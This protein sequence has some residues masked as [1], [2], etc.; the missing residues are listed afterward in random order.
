ML[1]QELGELELGN[2]FARSLRVERM[3]RRITAVAADGRLDPPRARARAAADEHEVLAHEP[4][5]TQE[6]LEPTMG[7]VRPGHDEQARGVTVQPVDDS[8]P[9]RLSASLDRL[10]EQALDE[11]AVGMAGRRMDDDPRRLVH[12]QQV[13]VLV[14]DSKALD[15][16]R[17][18]RVS[19]ALPEAR[20]PP[21]PRPP[22]DGSS[23]AVHRP[24]APRRR[25]EPLGPRPRAHLLAAREEA[26]QPLAGRLRR[27]DQPQG[28]P[29]W[30]LGRR[31]AREGAPRRLIRSS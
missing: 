26:I 10:L 29:R 23:D 24:R 14:G 3:A 5:S 31:A 22:V 28:E 18:E 25:Y 7:L 27:H 30:R 2:G 4:T 1:R 17:R 15:P 9:L 16:L 21:P 20:A 6:P 12:D 19:C 13:L 11:R 8:R